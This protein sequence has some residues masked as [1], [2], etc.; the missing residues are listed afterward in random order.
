MAYIPGVGKQRI[1]NLFGYPIRSKSKSEG[2]KVIRKI[3]IEREKYKITI[4]FGGGNDDAIND[5][6]RM[7]IDSFN[8]RIQ[9][10]RRYDK[11]SQLPVQSID[12]RSSG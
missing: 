10:E 12:K 2:G 9:K 7:L 4:V 1:Q 3:V 8:A 5:V 11:E 6:K